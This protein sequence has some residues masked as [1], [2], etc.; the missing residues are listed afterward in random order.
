MT[1]LYDSKLSTAISKYTELANMLVLP[2]IKIKTFTNVRSPLMKEIKLSKSAFPLVKSGHYLGSSF[3]YSKKIDKLAA[4]ILSTKALK[5]PLNS[6]S[7]SSRLSVLLNI[8][9]MGRNTTGNSIFKGMPNRAAWATSNQIQT[10][11]SS[12]NNFFKAIN[13][14]MGY[15]LKNRKKFKLSTEKL[16]IFTTL[17]LFALDKWA[18]LSNDVLDKPLI[19]NS[20]LKEKINFEKIAENYFKANNYKIIFDKLDYLIAND[21]DDVDFSFSK[22]YIKKLE[23]IR[24]LLN[25]DMENNSI[26]LVEPLMI[27]V[28]HVLA[29]KLGLLKSQKGALV[30]RK[31]ISIGDRIY[32]LGPSSPKYQNFYSVFKVLGILWDP[33]KQKFSNGLD[34]TGIGRHSVDHARVDPSRF[35]D[36]SIMKLICLLYAMVHLPNKVL[37]TNLKP[38]IKKKSKK[39]KHHR[40]NQKALAR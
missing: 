1:K 20:A 30:G 19:K 26:I 17:R 39:Y 14:S 12:Y 16:L 22:G 34:K 27:T 3:S 11:A 15:V 37:N 21:F 35:T 29:S 40:G 31:I 9:K 2:T 38:K 23:R 4:P 25:E 10:L 33:N 8:S 7:F 24:F 36:V 18:L 13:H 28:E 6:V 32:E 5:S